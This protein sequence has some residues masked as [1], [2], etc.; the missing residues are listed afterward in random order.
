MTTLKRIAGLHVTSRR[1]GGQEQKLFPPL[2]TKGR[3]IMKRYE[4]GGGGGWGRGIFEPQEIF[5]VIKFLV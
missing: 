3:T 4:G 1:Q 2:G 5:F